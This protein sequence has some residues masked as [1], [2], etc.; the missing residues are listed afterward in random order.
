[1]IPVEQNKLGVL[2]VFGDAFGDG[3]D[4][5]AGAEAGI[6]ESLEKGG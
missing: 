2:F 3:V 5:V 6:P 4:G 1:M